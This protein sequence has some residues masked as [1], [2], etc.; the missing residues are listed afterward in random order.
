[1]C[2][3]H[4][5]CSRREVKWPRE[6]RRDSPRVVEDRSGEV[7]Q[8]MATFTCALPLWLKSLPLGSSSILRIEVLPIVSRE[9]LFT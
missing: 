1:M 5:F 9:T 6:T 8:H 2:L 7:A 3:S 4:Y